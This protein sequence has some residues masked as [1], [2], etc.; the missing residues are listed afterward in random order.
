LET[1]STWGFAP[2]AT[3]RACAIA[4]ALIDSTAMTSSEATR[5]TEKIYLIGFLDID[6]LRFNGLFWGWV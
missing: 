4:S 2:E 6:L 3:S 5:L 1:R